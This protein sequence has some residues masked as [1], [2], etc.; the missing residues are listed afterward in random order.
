MNAMPESE[1][2]T[3]YGPPSAPQMGG[4]RRRRSQ[5]RRSKSRNS[6]RKNMSRVGMRRGKKSRVG[7]R[8]GKTLRR[9]RRRMYG[10]N[11]DEKGLI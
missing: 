9:K 8:R 5:Y 4:L 11:V 6:M 10:G 7:M 1:E 2:A 3:M